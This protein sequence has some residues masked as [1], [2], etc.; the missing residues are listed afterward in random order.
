VSFLLATGSAAGL[1]ATKELKKVEWT[2]FK[3]DGFFNMIYAS[4]TL[5]FLAFLCTAILSIL[6]SYALPKKV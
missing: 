3:L 6:S 5:L 1:G 4:A 2:K